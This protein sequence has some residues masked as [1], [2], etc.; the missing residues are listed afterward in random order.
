MKRTTILLSCSLSLLL[1]Q[2]PNALTQNE[3]PL[4]ADPTALPAPLLQVDHG[5]KIETKYDGFDREMVVTLHKMRVTCRGAKGIQ[6][7]LKDTCVSLLASLHC[8][9]QQ[10]D[11]VR[12][13][14]LQLI[15]ETKDWTKRH[16]LDERD[17]IVVADGERLTLG[18]MKLVNQDLNTSQ[19]IDVMKEV[20][21]VSFPHQTFQ[22]IARAQVVEVKVGRTTFELGEK[23]LAALRDLNNRVKP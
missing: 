6:S 10:L 12:H 7:A 16:P 3:T 11:Y 18:R 9:G 19:L 1:L 23:N 15:F 4:P 13:A 2:T 17:L 20:L 8:P 5:G 21:E 14:R 22:K